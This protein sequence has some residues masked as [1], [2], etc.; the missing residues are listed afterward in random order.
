MAFSRHTYP[1]RFGR[2]L[3]TAL[4]PPR[5]PDFVVYLGISAFLLQSLLVSP[6]WTSSPILASWLFSLLLL[7]SL[8]VLPLP[9]L[10]LSLL[11][12]NRPVSP[13]ACLLVVLSR[14][15]V[16]IYYPVANRLVRALQ[17]GGFLLQGLPL[18]YCVDIR[19]FCCGVKYCDKSIGSGLFVGFLRLAALSSLSHSVCCLTFAGGMFDVFGVLS[20][21]TLP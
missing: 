12:P 8:I 1:E 19:W 15:R 16:G 14:F 7:P 21:C 10:Q 5:M 18:F 4:F 6:C 17:A 20:I 9:S 13:R 2:V 11:L 3:R